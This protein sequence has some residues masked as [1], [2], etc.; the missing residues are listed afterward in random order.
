MKRA[1]LALIIIFCVV[2]CQK[3]FADEPANNN[4]VISA[5]GKKYHNPGCRTVKNVSKTLTITEAQ[6]LGYKPCKICKP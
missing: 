3:T 1:L 4:V 2:S 5:K 6:K